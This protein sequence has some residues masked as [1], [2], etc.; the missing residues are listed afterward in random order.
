M[1]KKIRDRLFINRRDREDYERLKRR[2]S[3]F[4][5]KENKELFMLAL[6]AGYVDGNRIPLKDRDGFVRL[7][8]LN[9]REKSIIKA[10]AIT[11]EDNLDVL[12]DEDKVY[13]IAEEYAASGI[14]LLKSNVLQECYIK[15]FENK[16]LE[17]YNKIKSKLK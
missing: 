10:I 8:Y 12:L 14:K 16:V 9:D 1:N 7:E 3:P 4:A 2:D 5:G 13:T 15:K 6:V 17:K 11:E